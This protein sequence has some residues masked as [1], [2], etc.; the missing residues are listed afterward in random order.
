MELFGWL[1][2][3]LLFRLLFISLCFYMSFRL[4]R[5]LRFIQ[6]LMK[7]FKKLL[8]FLGDRLLLEG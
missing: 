4:F 6:I 5:V 7:T 1:L 3:S 2:F 8:L